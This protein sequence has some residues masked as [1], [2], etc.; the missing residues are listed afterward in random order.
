MT[1]KK[2]YYEILG[3]SRDAGE[4]E[5]KAAYRKL[6]RKY[7]P[8]VNKG[9]P[10]AEEKF[11]QM[12]EAFAVLSDK[13]KRQRYDR[14]GHEAF[15]PGF[16]PFAGFDFDRAGVGDL[17][18]L[19][20]MFGLGGAARRRARRGPR[21]GQDLRRSLRVSFMDAVRGTSLKLR[22]PRRVACDAC[23][24]AGSAA[25]Q[26][27]RPCAVCQGTGQRRQTA[28]GMQMSAPCD[29]CGG[30]GTGSVPCSRCAGSGAIRSEE[31]VAVRIPAGVQAGSVVRVPA[32]GDAGPGGG[33]AGDL[34]LTIEVEPHPEFRREGRDLYRDLPVGL[35][36]AALGGEVRVPTLDGAATISVP[37]GT[38]SGQKLRLRGRGVPATRGVAAGDLYAVIQIH[39]PK[40]LDAR[41]RELLQE[42]ARLNPEPDA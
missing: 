6:A 37:P 5:I 20:E 30:S 21:R 18:D 19:F 35:A 27:R 24:G 26:A 16:D 31:T 22:I 23:G 11:K 10:A 13:E 7:H 36:R 17:G 32:K 34:Y 25:G 2:D 9:D 28:F 14:G 15:G 1:K 38:R 8:D 42:F 41:S 29:A 33:P 3:V 4:K 39:P 40:Q 12:S